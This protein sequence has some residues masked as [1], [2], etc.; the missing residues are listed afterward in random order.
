MK[1][2]DKLLSFL[3]EE[4]YDINHETENRIFCS[5]GEISIEINWG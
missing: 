5:K 2:L 3:K 4:G 1:V